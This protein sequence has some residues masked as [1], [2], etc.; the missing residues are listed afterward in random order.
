VRGIARC[1]CT[2]PVELRAG[3]LC[4]ATCGA[5]IALELARYT[6]RDGERPAG[7]SR[8]A[9]LRVFRRALV[10]GDAH[11]EGRACV[12]SREAWERYARTAPPTPPR[13]SRPRL[14][15]ASAL[16]VDDE[17]LAEL[18]AVEVPDRGAA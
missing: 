6:Q 16:S 8:I 15:L 13:R 3:A 11:H 12:M 4:C 18:G 14:A 2:G 1:T 10:A 7:K 9:Y 17:V 5:R